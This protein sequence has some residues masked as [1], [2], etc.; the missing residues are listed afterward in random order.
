MKK[1]AD[2]LEK[3]AYMPTLRIGTLRASVLRAFEDQNPFLTSQ[4]EGRISLQNPFNKVCYIFKKGSHIIL[5][6]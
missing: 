3:M 6:S 1:L 4:N 5:I 2:F